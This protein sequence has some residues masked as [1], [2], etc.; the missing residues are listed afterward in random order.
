MR[1]TL[2]LVFIH[3]FKGGDDTFAV[4]PEHLRALVSHALPNIDVV[5]V[6]YP[7]FE[8]RGELRDC[9][10]RFREWLQNKVIDLEVAR[11]TPSPTVD[12]SV[13]VI[14][15]GHSMGGI[16]AA[17]T[18]LQL[19]SEQPIT[20]RSSAQ[21]PERPNF[22]SNTTLGSTTSTSHPTPSHH[23]PDSMSHN[24]MFP[25]IQG[26]LAFDT[27]FLGLAPGMVAHGLEGGHKVVANAYNTYSEVASMFGWGSKSEPNVSST[28]STSGA[29]SIGALPAPASSSTA[30]AAAA[31]KWQ[32]WGKYA[33]F[34][35]AAGAVVAGGAAA[36]YSQREKLSAG[37]K[38]ASDHLLFVG[39]LFKP[40]HL[41]KRVESLEQ[42]CKERGAGCANLYT[43]LGK[44]ASGG[45]GITETLA[46]RER[47]FCNLPVHVSRDRKEGRDTMQETS[48]G[49]KWIKAVNDKASDETTAHV[50]MFI[51]RDNPGFYA[52]GE[53]AKECIARWTDRGWYVSSTGPTF[54]KPDTNHMGLGESPDGGWVKPDA[55]EIRARERAKDRYGSS[56]KH[57]NVDADDADTEGTL[58]KD[59]DSLDLHRGKDGVDLLDDEDVRMRD[60]DEELEGSVIVEKMAANGE[61]PLPKSRSNT[62]V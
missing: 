37:W 7:K 20:A 60:E 39:E 34:A 16:V 36:L 27:P 47:T 30:D 29:K 22:P 33:M 12:P 49:F 42:E 56:Y 17:E 14:L 54:L 32:A 53:Y 19:A 48:N 55:D 31:P 1:K 11:S 8:T 25:H 43:N 40:E 57:S 4:F 58:G 50:S 44:G 21:N 10:A 45:Y 15:I 24:F 52:L 61:V 18:Y 46:G 3:G 38:W 51:P 35:G 62:G 9:V 59:W 5:T 6:T 2:L 28:S 23:E 41:R 13:H 26:V